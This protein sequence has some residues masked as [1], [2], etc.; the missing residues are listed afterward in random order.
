MDLFA[1]NAKTG[2]DGKQN[3]GC[4]IASNVADKLRLPPGPSSM[5]HINR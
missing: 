4:G 5:G 3:V 2:G 1:L